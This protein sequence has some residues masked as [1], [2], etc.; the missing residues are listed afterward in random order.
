MTL[1]QKQEKIID[2]IYYEQ[3]GDG[4]YQEIK[5]LVKEVVKTHK[6]VIECYDYVFMDEN[7]NVVFEED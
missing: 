1:D 6:D 3:I 4:L 2:Y 7:D 5:F